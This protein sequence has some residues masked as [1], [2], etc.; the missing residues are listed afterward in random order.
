MAKKRRGEATQ[1]APT[2]LGGSA[3]SN[4]VAA[5]T[6]SKGSSSSGSR[7]R[8]PP[9]TADSAGKS[10]S[11]PRGFNAAAASVAATSAIAAHEIAVSV[12]P[13]ALSWAL[14]SL[15]AD[16]GAG[17]EGGGGSRVVG[18]REQGHLLPR[19]RDTYPTPVR[20]LACPARLCRVVGDC[21]SG[22][23][24]F[25]V[26]AETG[27]QLLLK[28][29]RHEVAVRLSVMV[30]REGSERADLVTCCVCFCSKGSRFPTKTRCTPGDFASTAGGIHPPVRQPS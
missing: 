12:T 20:L 7:Y 3:S 6:V 19:S 30:G 24:R 1:R 28:Q 15:L 26:L 10:A 5:D 8:S 23:C 22:A 2:S 29:I 17:A 16:G 14:V 11:E 13:T 25:P 18:A 21:G 9:N 4:L 27:R